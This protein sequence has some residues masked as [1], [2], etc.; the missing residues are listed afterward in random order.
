[1]ELCFL[2]VA[3]SERSPRNMHAACCSLCKH[4]TLRWLI[5]LAY[6]KDGEDGHLQQYGDQ[7]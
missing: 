5:L 2:F 4:N 6:G 1:V 7:S 3:V